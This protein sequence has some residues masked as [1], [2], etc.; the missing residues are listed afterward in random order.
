MASLLPA[1]RLSEEE[2]K[3]LRDLQAQMLELY[4]EWKRQ[5]AEGCCKVHRFD[6]LL[7]LKFPSEAPSARRAMVRAQLSP[8][9]AAPPSRLQ[10][11]EGARIPP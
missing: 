5:Q 2:L 10:S 3:E 1:P 7:K 9:R 11:P 8:T 6:E 4:Q